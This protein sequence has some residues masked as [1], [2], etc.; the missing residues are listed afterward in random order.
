MESICDNKAGIKAVSFDFSRP[1]MSIWVT[2][3]RHQEILE[4]NYKLKLANDDYRFPALGEDLFV[5][6]RGCSTK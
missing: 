1:G 4:R 2:G 3:C 5:V 6:C